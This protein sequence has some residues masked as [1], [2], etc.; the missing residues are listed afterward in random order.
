MHR[1]IEK[2]HLDRFLRSG[3]V[4]MLDTVISV[5]ASVL[6]LFLSNIFFSSV[7]LDTRVR[8]WWTGWAL[9][10]SGGAVLRFR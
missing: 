8:L 1:L 6:V 2:F 5:A 10:F 7:V 9:L 3:A 4:L